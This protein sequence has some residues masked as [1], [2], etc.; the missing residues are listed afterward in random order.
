MPQGNYTF[1]KGSG[2][3]A[4]ATLVSPELSE[5]LT[6]LCN[7]LEMPKASLVRFLVNRGVE[8]LEKKMVER[9]NKI[10]SGV[11]A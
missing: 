5:R 3:K 8:D 4:I 9:V 11:I 1:S 2:A 6:T 7:I 10:E